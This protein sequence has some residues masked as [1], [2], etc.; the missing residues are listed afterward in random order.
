MCRKHNEI[1]SRKYLWL[2]L[3][4]FWWLSISR[5]V[6]MCYFDRTKYFLTVSWYHLRIYLSTR[7][8]FQQ[9]GEWLHTSWI[10]KLSRRRFWRTLIWRFDISR[11]NLSKILHDSTSKWLIWI[12]QWR[13]KW[14]ATLWIQSELII[15]MV[16]IIITKT[17][18]KDQ[19]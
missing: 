1:L 14:S 3:A 2:L 18:H 13:K 4:L 11:S 16:S 19:K 8:N 5:T 15:T 17:G 10:F 12:P 9:F 7:N 6:I